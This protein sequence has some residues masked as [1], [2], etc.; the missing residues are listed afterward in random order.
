MPNEVRAQNYL[1]LEVKKALTSFL[2]VCLF[3]T[4]GPSAVVLSA[5][6]GCSC[7]GCCCC[8]AHGLRESG[9]AQMLE[10]TEG[11]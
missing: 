4:A 6:S 3:G 11:Q 2:F 10:D 9:V 7:K 5:V 8:T 1:N